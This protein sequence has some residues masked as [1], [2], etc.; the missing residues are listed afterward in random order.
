MS[1]RP[2]NAAATREAILH[3]AVRH[4]ARA[5]YDGV[6]VRQIAQDAGVTAMLVNRYF[7]SKELLFA[8][9]VDAAF[10]SPV[11]IAER[12][13]AL[14]ADTAASLVRG[15]DPSGDAPEAFLILLRSVSD[16]AAVPIVRA[17]IERHVGRRL[18]AQLDRPDHELRSELV[19]SVISGV[20]LMRRVVGT[21]ALTDVAPDDLAALLL[22]VLTTIIDGPAD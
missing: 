1:N 4:F 3:S 10:A 6:G 11:F 13:S 2:R 18:A 14:A 16:P 5:G 15:T 19:L 12:S 9:A 21:T 17:A 20:L 8:E 7:G 22:P